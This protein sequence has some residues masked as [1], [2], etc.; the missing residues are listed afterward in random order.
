MAG[1]CCYEGPPDGQG[2]AQTQSGMLMSAEH[3]SDPRLLA[4]VRG[5]ARC[6]GDHDNVVW[7]ALTRPI[8]DNDAVVGVITW[9][10][11]CPC[12]TNG[13]PILQAEIPMEKAAARARAQD[14][15]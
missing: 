9:T 5:C 1:R 15:R 2:I 4:S 7:K 8:V 13:E 12:P 14:A 6:G 3:T 10:H 11:W